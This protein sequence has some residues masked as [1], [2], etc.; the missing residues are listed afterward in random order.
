MY[1]NPNT[2]TFEL[3][4]ETDIVNGELK[5]TNAL[6]KI[7]SVQKIVRGSNKVNLSG[8]SKGIYQYS[9]VQDNKSLKTGKIALE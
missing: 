6:G 4:I 8:L 2:G 1:P 9:V 5:V 7:V 3:M